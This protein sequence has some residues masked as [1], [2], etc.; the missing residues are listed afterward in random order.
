MWATLF[1]H[2]AIAL[3]QTEDGYIEYSG[4]AAAPH[5]MDYLY[6]ERHML[7]Y[8]GGRLAERVVLYTCGDGAPFARKTVRYVTPF[9]PDF[10]LED[11]ST[12]LREGVRSV[13]DVRSVFFRSGG[14]AAEKARRLPQDA[15]LVADAGFDE[16]I[17][18]HWQPLLAGKAPEMHFLVPSRLEDLSFEI[19]HLRSETLE[20][21]RIEVFRLNLAG[22]LGWFMSPLEVAYSAGEHDLLRYAGPSD[23]RDA[24]GNNIQVQITYR[25]RDRM[26]SGAAAISLAQQ[27]PLAACH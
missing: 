3:N 26:P 1:V 8:H 25:A 23:L 5:S 2:P 20:G 11:A 4:T 15:E 7:R 17:R 9:A 6:G 21:I 10:L 18:A 14:A 27:A 22:L 19:R 13:D 24:A 16:F 12:G